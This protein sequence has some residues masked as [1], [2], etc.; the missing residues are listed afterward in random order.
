MLR[1]GARSVGG[2]RHIARR[3]NQDNR[4]TGIVDADSLELVE[5][6]DEHWLFTCA[7]AENDEVFTS[8]V[9]ALVKIR[10]DG[11]Y[12]ESIDIRNHQDIKP[13]FGTKITEFRTRFQ[14]GP[15]V[16]SGPIVQKSLDVRVKGRAFL[17]I[18]FDEAEAVKYSDF[19]HVGEPQR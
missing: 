6:T 9:D 15:A 8:N 4:V 1:R 13:G 2:L 19:E 3:S 7:P 17:F 18:G 12:V 11:R 14:F 5:E 16:E 10:K